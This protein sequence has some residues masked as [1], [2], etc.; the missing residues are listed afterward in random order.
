MEPDPPRPPELRA[1]RDP[2]A[3]QRVAMIADA[4][5]IGLW[6][7]DLHTGALYW[8]AANRALYGLQ[9]GEPPPSWPEYL[10]R[11]VHPD[12]RERFVAEVARADQQSVPLRHADYRVRTA[13]GRERWIYSWSAREQRDG[14][15]Q[16]FGLNVDVTDRHL[17]EAERRQRERAEQARHAQSALLARVSHE[18]RTPMNALL[19]FADLLAIDAGAPLSATQAQHVARIRAAGRH[20]LALIDDLLGLA[21][22][23]AEERAPEWR[24]VEL[25]TTLAQGLEWVRGLADAQGLRLEVEQPLGGFC[26]SR[27]TC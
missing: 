1:V 6:T 8:S 3:D 20:L 25:A 21:A 16:A 27:P 26:R 17:A 24:T 19:G 10:E 15:K 14:V 7:R 23:D 11:F 9:P 4:A 2:K 5:G 18:L 12:D 22:A 13:D